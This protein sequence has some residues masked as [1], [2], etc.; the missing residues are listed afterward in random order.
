MLF[1]GERGVSLDKDQPFPAS[2]YVESA[3]HHV[4]LAL[5]LF[6]TA[7]VEVI[8]RQ[9]QQQTTSLDECDNKGNLSR[10]TPRKISL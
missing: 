4:D 1:L 3:A 8:S 6:N 9:S 5:R 2:L 7:A 10:F